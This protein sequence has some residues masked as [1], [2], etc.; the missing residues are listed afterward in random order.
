MPVSVVRLRVD[1][2]RLTAD[3]YRAA[4]PLRGRLI[5]RPTDKWQT[6]GGASH[7]AELAKPGQGDHGFL[8][9]PLFNP[10]VEQID[11]RG[12]VLSGYETRLV[13][14]AVQHVE[15]VWLVSFAAAPD[16]AAPA[17]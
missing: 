17:R 16:D 4:E 1:G 6:G 10:V 13:G 7:I 14:G 12:I 15:Q 2:R 11:H 9:A 8:G 3:E 5:L